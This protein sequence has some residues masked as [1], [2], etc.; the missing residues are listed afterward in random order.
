MLIRPAHRQCASGK[1][2]QHHRLTAG[3]GN[4]KNLLLSAGQVQIGLIPAGILIALIPL[5][6]F[7]ARIQPKA[8][9]DHITCLAHRFDFRIPVLSHTEIADLLPVQMAPF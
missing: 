6:S 1:K 7:Q 8:Q 5:F 3:T 2:H 9:N 4:L